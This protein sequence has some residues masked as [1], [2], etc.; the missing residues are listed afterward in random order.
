MNNFSRI[1]KV[2]DEYF[3]NQFPARSCGE[4]SRLSKDAD[5]E[6]ETIAFCD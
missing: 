2:Y 1:N 4:V 6:I 5:I 3:T